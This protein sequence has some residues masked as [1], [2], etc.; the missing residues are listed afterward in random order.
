MDA[1]L[2]CK[3][4]L[5][6][7]Q[8]DSSNLE[9]DFVSAHPLKNG[10]IAHIFVAFIKP[11]SDR[12]PCMHKILKIW[13]PKTNKFIAETFPILDIEACLWTIFSASD[14]ELIVFISRTV[15]Q[16]RDAKTLAILQESKLGYESLEVLPQTNWLIGKLRSDQMHGINTKDLTLTRVLL[17][18]V[19]GFCALPSGRIV[20]A[21]FVGYQN[22]LH[23]YGADLKQV[24][25]AR[26]GH[27]FYV[28][29]IGND[30]RALSERFI[31]IMS[32]THNQKIIFDLSTKR[33]HIL[34]WE[35]HNITLLDD[36]IFIC[37][38]NGA[39][40][41][42]DSQTFCPQPLNL[43]LPCDK[44][45]SIVFSPETNIVVMAVRPPYPGKAY[46][47]YFR[48][49]PAKE[50][51]NEI[52]TT[53]SKF[54]GSRPLAKIIAEYSHDP[55]Q[56]SLI[57]TKEPPV[58]ERKNIFGMLYRLFQGKKTEK[59]NA[60]TELARQKLRSLQTSFLG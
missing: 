35:V 4:Q 15:I 1:R 31:L 16:R 10:N 53:V 41:S 33:A 42:F 43:K 50:I 11:S 58:S 28:S 46:P 47:L 30:L 23:L 34:K 56:L 17:Q 2:E 27:H 25:F 24:S 40:H 57:V 45:E 44:V 59:Q 3:T 12:V 29:Y 48:T 20:A 21:P 54:S 22:T 38:I 51:E 49:S 52:V 14:D 37:T 26:V 32:Y 55:L 18:N 7:H 19:N 13:D 8:P 5:A 60:S 36:N 9:L 6:K 39:L